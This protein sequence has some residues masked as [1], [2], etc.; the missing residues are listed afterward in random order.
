MEIMRLPQRFWA[1]KRDDFPIEL[2]QRDLLDNMTSQVPRLMSGATT[3]ALLYGPP[4]TG[5]TSAA[6]VI[7]KAVR[8][9]RY[10][11]FFLSVADILRTFPSH[12]PAGED[13]TYRE[14]AYQTEA[15]LLDGL[16]D[17]Y[18]ANEF[19]ASETLALVKHRQDNLMLTII[20]TSLDDEKIKKMYSPKMISLLGDTA[21]AIHCPQVFASGA[22]HAK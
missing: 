3:L 2:R 4:G 5:K 13:M 19:V 10:S 15:L 17:G 21:V 18:A 8:A 22:S 11:T 9:H 12:E 7:L 14:R 20:T 16:G 6:A 1:A